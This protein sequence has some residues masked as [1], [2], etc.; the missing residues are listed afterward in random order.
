MGLST[1]KMSRSYSNSYRSERHVPIISAKRSYFHPTWEVEPWER[2]HEWPLPSYSS[3]REPLTTSM[4]MEP[5]SSS[6]RMEP[7]SSPPMRMLD[8]QFHDLQQEMDQRMADM[9]ANMLSL[10]PSE[11]YVKP[12]EGISFPKLDQ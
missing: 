5:L 4:R 7:I 9:R 3:Y 10:H 8:H 12:M 1:N 6:M 11:C 2:R